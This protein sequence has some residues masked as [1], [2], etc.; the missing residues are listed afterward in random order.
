[1][2]SPVHRLSS[3]T[4]TGRAVIAGTALLIFGS[5]VVPLVRAEELPEP[6]RE[7]RGVWVTTVANIDWPSAK[8]LSVAGQQAELRRQFDLFARLGFNAVV[9]QVRGA[10]DAFYASPHEP[11]SEYLTGKMGVAPK[12]SYDPL[13]FAIEEARKRGL[14]LHAWVNPFRAGHATRKSDFAAN[15]VAKK[16]PE[17]VRPYG[18]LHW[19]DPGVP[20]ARDYVLRILRDIVQRYDIDALH[21]DDYFYPYPEKGREFPDWQ[22]YARYRANGGTLDHTAWRRQNI[23]V[24]VGRLHKMMR[25]IKPG[26]KLGISPAGIWKTG[27]P[28]SIRGGGSFETLH[29]DSRGWLMNGWV[30]YLSPQ[31]YWRIRDKQQSF[32]VLLSWWKSQNK[33][34]RHVWPGLYTSRVSDGTPAEWRADEIEK[35]I[36]IIRKE[37]GSKGAL[38]FSAKPVIEN[39]GG[40]ADRIG[41]LYRERALIPASPWLDVKKPLAPAVNQEGP[42][43]IWRTEDSTPVRWWVIQIRRADKWITLI[44]PPGIRSYMPKNVDTEIAIRAVDRTGGISEAGRIKIQ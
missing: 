10:S 37:T 14:A 38:H 40:I 13:K 27:V 6:R 3:Y 15:H 8:N 18:R 43:I 11:W 4:L 39:K 26:V 20:E 16:H 34:N 19:I 28:A 17:W 32:P 23:D 1:M 36:A 7:F 33:K 24:F 30:D 29:A 5:L 21:L 42:E 35:Q 25:D 9:F 22:T 44:E 41:T 12:P 31:L 2:V